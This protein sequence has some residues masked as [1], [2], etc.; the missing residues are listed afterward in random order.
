MIPQ[1]EKA[2]HLK[3]PTGTQDILPGEIPLWRLVEETAR[4]IF[5][6]YG[7]QEIRT[8]IFEHVNL[9]NRS[10]GSTT[11]IVEKEMYLLQTKDEPTDLVLRPEQTASVVR[12]YLEHNL[13]QD[14]QFQKFYYLGP[15]F[16]HERPQKGR[17]RQF[18]QIG[19]EALGSHDYLVDVETIDL[20]LTFFRTLGIN[21]CT[22]N[23]NS[24]GCSKCRTKYREVLQDN[25]IEDKSNL[26]ETCQARF[27]RNLFRIMDCK[28]KKCR[29]ITGK[30]PAIK[31]YLCGDCQE[32]FTK[33]L[34]AL[35][36]NSLSYVLEPHLMRGFDYYT[37]TIFEIT[38]LD[39]GAQNA[40]CGGGRYDDLVA[41]LG[42]PA[43][44]AVGFAIGAERTILALEAKGQNDLALAQPQPLKV[45]IAVISNELRTYGFN[46][47][48]E[49]RKEG[50]ASDMDYETKSI[51]AQMRL[52]NRLQAEYVVIIGPDEMKKQTVKIKHMISGIEKEV[53]RTELLTNLITAGDLAKR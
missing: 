39:L 30:T 42:G 41:D 47:L 13:Y 37:K 28:N 4:R 16:R 34:T 1:P 7:Y 5:E 44:G 9:F 14:K 10:I 50:V 22:L 49:L 53:K 24:M 48:H 46:I 3:A 35:Q 6:R 31:D 2:M 32:H 21:N 52:A 15:F 33:V 51:K 27:Q 20:A 11:D 25:L 23:I 45:F 8:P 36:E 17:T 38:H 26:C 29:E 40:L 43:V 18:H 19:I 12:A